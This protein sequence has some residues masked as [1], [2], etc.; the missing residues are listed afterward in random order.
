MLWDRRIDRD[1][2]ERCE[3]IEKEKE[4]QQRMNEVRDNN[5]VWKWSN[6]EVIA[7]WKQSMSA[8]AREIEIQ[9]DEE[10]YACMCVYYSYV[11]RADGALLSRT[12]FTCWVFNKASMSGVSL[13]VRWQSI[14]LHKLS[15]TWKAKT[16]MFCESGSKSVWLRLCVSTGLLVRMQWKF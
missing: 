6:Q 1:G 14:F 7:G 13:T 9:G 16:I 8:K 12:S 4:I 2:W 10:W 3:K 5:R 15:H 11:S